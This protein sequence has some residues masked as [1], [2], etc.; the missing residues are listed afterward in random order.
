MELKFES[1]KDSPDGDVGE[2]IYQVRDGNHRAFVAK[3]IGE[4]YIWC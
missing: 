2:L 3:Y 4:P 1:L